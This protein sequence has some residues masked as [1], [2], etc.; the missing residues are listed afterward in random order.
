MGHTSFAEATEK[1]GRELEGLILPAWV[2]TIGCVG[3]L[4]VKWGKIWV[5][6]EEVAHGVCCMHRLR[7]VRPSQPS[8]ARHKTENVQQLEFAAFSPPAVDGTHP[9]TLPIEVLRPLPSWGCGW[10]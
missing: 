1:W 6:A 2:S 4:A 10:M 3:P 5:R 9:L 7:T 8:I